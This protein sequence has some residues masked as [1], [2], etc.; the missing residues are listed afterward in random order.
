MYAKRHPLCEPCDAEGRVT[1]MQVVDHIIPLRAGGARL[2]ERNLHSMC[3]ACH[4]KKT[5]RD[6][7]LYPEAYGSD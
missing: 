3:N 4:A 1:P 5:E 7:G 6:R 2:D